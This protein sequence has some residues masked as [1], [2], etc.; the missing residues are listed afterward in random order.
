MKNLFDDAFENVKVIKD[1]RDDEYHDA[2][3]IGIKV[4]IGALV[5]VGTVALGAFI[6][7]ASAALVTV[8]AVEAGITMAGTAVI[9][10]AKNYR[11]GYDTSEAIV[12]GSVDG[13]KAGATYFTVGSIMSVKPSSA[14]PKVKGQSFTERV[15]VTA[16]E[17]PYLKEIDDLD[18]RTIVRD[19]LTMDKNQVD[20][21][22]SVIKSA[23]VD[24]AKLVVVG[25]IIDLFKNDEEILSVT[26]FEGIDEDVFIQKY[27]GY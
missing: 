14:K 16:S 3:N 9:Q 8:I 15:K 25:D 22:L 19:R 2:L 21:L 20:Y 24:S 27:N 5:A 6:L 26:N 17:K 1:Y 7:P 12:D 10:S 23:P 11:D 13:I 4:G 18:F